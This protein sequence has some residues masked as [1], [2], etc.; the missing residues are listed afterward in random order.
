MYKGAGMGETI[1]FLRFS[2]MIKIQNSSLQGWGV[3]ERH[4][5]ILIQCF[6]ILTPCSLLAGFFLLV[7]F[8]LFSGGLGTRIKSQQSGVRIASP[9]SSSSKKYPLKQ[10]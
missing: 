9:F 2:H 10:V 3:G 4:M 8:S 1:T 6:Y 7:T 5:L